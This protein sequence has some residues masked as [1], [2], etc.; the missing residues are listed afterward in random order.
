MNLCWASDFSYNYFKD[1]LKAA[2]SNF[3]SHLL[4]EAPQ[5]VGKLDNGKSKLILRHDIDVSPMRA[6]RMARI[7]KSLGIFATYLVMTESSLYSLEDD[8]SRDILQKIVDMGHEIGLHVDPRT[9]GFDSIEAK[10]DSGCKELETISSLPVLAVSFHRPPKKYQ[11]GPL[12]IGTR[13]NAYSEKLMK[14]YLSDSTG[15]WR[16]GEPLPQLLR[17]DKPLL[18]LL[19]HPIWWGDEHMTGKERLKAFV[20][21]EMR[22]KHQ[23]Y[24]KALRDNIKSTINV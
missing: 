16:Y 18:Q 8:N 3:E 14:W 19:V 5:I 20:L 15:C 23:G 22:G 13:V 11:E 9:N 7:E 17:P 21:E 1:L 6:L 12:M 10:I 4:S 2:K 24:A